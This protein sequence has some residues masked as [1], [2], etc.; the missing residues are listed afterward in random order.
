MG[1]ECSTTKEGP[2]HDGLNLTPQNFIYIQR[3][4][5]ASSSTRMHPQYLLYCGSARGSV[6]SYSLTFQHH[7]D[8]LERHIDLKRRLSGWLPRDHR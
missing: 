8:T 2:L 3:R 1:E 6:A 5:D 4:K 7:P